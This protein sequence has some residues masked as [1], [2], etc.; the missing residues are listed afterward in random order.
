MNPM[1]PDGPQ[2]RQAVRGGGGGGPGSG[3]GLP[4]L[5]TP[6]DD[7]PK[8]PQ[9]EELGELRQLL[10]RM[11][12]EGLRTARLLPAQAEASADAS[13]AEGAGL[14]VLPETPMLPETIEGMLSALEQAV[15]ET[16]E[17]LLNPYQAGA[18]GALKFGEWQDNYLALERQLNLLAAHLAKVSGEEERAL[19]RERLVDF[20]LEVAASW[21]YQ[22]P[23][24]GLSRVLRVLIDLGDAPCT[25]RLLGLIADG[26][27][28]AEGAWATLAQRVLEE[29]WEQPRIIIPK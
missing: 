14:P 25:R 9:L 12:F 21:A 24:S 29:S 26:R 1:N 23:P 16:E 13:P 18:P 3:A 10:E 8:A 5:P 17:R 15:R 22:C 4:S 20:Y 11:R 19:V 2:L 28:A 27:V 7:G 6:D